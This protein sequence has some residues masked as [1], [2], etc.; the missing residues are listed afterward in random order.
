MVA[1]KLTF[2]GFCRQAKDAY[3]MQF[4]RKEWPPA[5]HAPDVRAP[6]ATFG[7]VASAP[8]S[9]TRPEVLTLIQ[10]QTSGTENPTKKGNCHKCGKPGC[11]AN[12][13]PELANSSRKSGLSSSSRYRQDCTNKQ[14]SW[15]TIP[16][17]PGTGNSKK[18]KDK[19][20][21]WCDKCCRWTVTHTTA[22]HTGCER[23]PPAPA[24]APRANLSV[25]TPDPSVWI[26]DFTGKPN[27][28]SPPRSLLNL[29]QGA[30]PWL[31]PVISLAMCAIVPNLI[32]LAIYLASAIPWSSILAWS[33]TTFTKS[34]SVT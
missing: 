15:R 24:P 32:S 34:S 11:W 22:T 17:P 28:T 33:P 9:I 29:I 23:R 7:N 5:S 20:F 3:R 30:N 19:S 14:K 13:C 10:S 2:H 6:A 27:D 12:K 25:L 26:L 8:T 1:K 31:L 18:V 16:P 4:D 21:N